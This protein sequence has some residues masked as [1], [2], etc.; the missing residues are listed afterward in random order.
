[1]C[2]YAVN[3]KVYKFSE[4]GNHGNTRLVG[5]R[6]V[7]PTRLNCECT[8]NQLRCTYPSSGRLSSPR[9]SSLF[10]MFYFSL[11]LFYSTDRIFS[12]ASSVYRARPQTLRSESPEGRA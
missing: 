2:T 1:M 3:K 5:C 7:I 9:T 8:R 6:S 4:R 10:E 11:Y 12:C